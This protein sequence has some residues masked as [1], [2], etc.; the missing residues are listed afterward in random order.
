MLAVPV[1]VRADRGGCAGSPRRRRRRV[2]SDACSG[3]PLLWRC[4]TQ[5]GY[6]MALVVE[7][8]SSLIIIII[9][10]TL[11]V[12]QP[13]CVVYVC[14]L[15]SHRRWLSL[16]GTVCADY[17]FRFVARLCFLM[18]TSRYSHCETLRFGRLL[19][20][21]RIEWSTRCVALFFLCSS[22]LVDLMLCFRNLFRNPETK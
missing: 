5:K 9:R 8:G 17:D 4:H 10:S 7:T 13:H 14:V 21:T 3:R 12:I 6:K 2:L 20:T 1:G 18:N 19:I 16:W 22:W 11:N 15:C